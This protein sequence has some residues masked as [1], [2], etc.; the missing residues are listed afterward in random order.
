M[1][2]AKNDHIQIATIGVG[3]MGSGDTQMAQQI[4]G[5][6]LM[7][8][9]DLYDGRLERA[10]EKWG[11]DI[12]TTRDY[13]EI[14]ARKDV[15][16]VI[17]G[18]S[19]HYHAQISID[20]MNAGK[21]VYCEKPMVQK[22]EQGHA[23]WE[24]Q[25]KTGR[26]L[27]VGS[28]YASSMVFQ[29]AREL[30]KQG[31]IGQLNLVEA[32]LDRSTAIGAW[33]YSIPP[34][35]NPERVDWD[36]YVAITKKRPFDA[37]RFFRWRNYQDYGTGVA[38]DLYVHLLTGLHVV[39]GSMGPRRVYSTG[40]TRFWL[41]ERDVADVTLALVDYPKTEQHPEFTLALR[42]NLAS[43]GS[44]EGFGVRFVGSEGVMTV[45][46]TTLTLQRHPRETEPGY[47]IGTFPKAVQEQFLKDYNA[48]Y[49]KGKPNADAMRPDREDV[50][51][52]PR[53]HSP[54]LEHHRNF[55]NAIRSR[56]PFFEDAEFGLRTAGPAL[57][58]NHSYYE[59]KI[60]EWDPKSLKRT[61]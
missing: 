1:P 25:K 49:P 14:L 51:S 15:D 43:G 3:G 60:C 40:G 45:G 6:K 50:F 53:D 33:Q 17:I 16:A 55:Y 8:V 22:I 31:A 39:T 54:H 57:L 13:R 38:G 42:V 23:V 2:F 5:V 34:D 30:F 27:Q 29:K 21:D 12:A 26:I 18:T 19:D 36:R 52:P 61:A 59:H 37:K 32:W 11:A 56:N 24:T 44:I 10:K 47:T 7:A 4:P 35:A 9:A 28:Q 41:D 20:A 48:K 58:C 46:Y